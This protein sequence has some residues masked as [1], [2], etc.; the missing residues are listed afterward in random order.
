M[1]SLNVFT[2]AVDLLPVGINSLKALEK[3]LGSRPLLVGE[4]SFSVRIRL[5]AQNSECI[6][7]VVDSTIVVLDGSL[8]IRLWALRGVR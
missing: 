3:S 5:V 7:L 6:R 1:D 8:I 2:L 4:G